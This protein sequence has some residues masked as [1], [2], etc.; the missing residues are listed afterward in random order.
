MNEKCARCGCKFECKS[1]D[2]EQCQCNTI[3]LS[4]EELS[5]IASKFDNCLCAKCLKELHSEFLE[6]ETQPLNMTIALANRADLKEILDLQKQCYLSEGELYDDY[7]IPP[8]TQD[9]ESIEADFDQGTVFLKGTIDGQIIASVRGFVKNETAYIGRLI[10]KPEF[11]NNKFGQKMM[12]CIESQLNDCTRHE[13]FTGFKSQGNIYLYNKLGYSEFKREKVNDKLAMV[14]ME[15]YI[16][17][18]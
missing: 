6:K 16:P 14:Y 13:L 12:Y 7:S 10:V 5:F 2:I 15:K 9:I 8:L 17:N 11:Q 1:D 4:S 18:F 3:I